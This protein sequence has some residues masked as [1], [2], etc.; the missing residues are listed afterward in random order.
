[1]LGPLNS[2]KWID[3]LLPEML[4]LGMLNEDHGHREGTRLAKELATAVDHV[5]RPHGKMFALVSAYSSIPTESWQQ[6]ITKL[7]PV[8][9]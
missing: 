2:V 5:M 7:S 4:W 6:I 1:M 8:D 3:D 9:L